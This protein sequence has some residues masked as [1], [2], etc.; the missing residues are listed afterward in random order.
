[1]QEACQAAAGFDR[2]TG[3]AYGFG[4]SVNVSSRQFR[5]SE[6]LIADVEDA[7]ND[8]GLKPER[9]TLEITE[10][11]PLDDLDGA[12]EVVRRLRA[13]QVRV[14]LDDFGTGYS[15]LAYVRRIPVSGL[16]IDQSFIADLE[17]TATAAIVKAILGI[18]DELDITVTAEGAETLA[19]VEAIRALGCRLVQ[20]HFYGDA[21]PK[22]AFTR[23]LQRRFPNQRT[24]TVTPLRTAAS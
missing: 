5:D 6:R 11:S 23:L 1:L 4:I 20:G 17:D 10:S 12:V 16:K 2:L 3:A 8:S 21:I 19:Q 14:A 24:G 7:L 15:S 13:M 22:A 9:L 18:A